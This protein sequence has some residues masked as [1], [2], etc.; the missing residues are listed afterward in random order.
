MAA[1]THRLAGGAL[2]ALAGCGGGREAPPPSAPVVAASL[3]EDPAGRTVVAEVDGRP[4]YADCVARQA[5]ARGI[6]LRAAVDECIGFELLAREAER[7]GYAAHPEVLEARETEVVRAFIDREFAAGF[8]GPEDVP[9]AEVE[10]FYRQY[11]DQLYVHPEW[12]TSRHVLARL[13]FK[14][15]DG[16]VE[17][18][19]ARAFVDALR[20]GLAGRRPDAAELERVAREL[21]AHH[22]GVKLQI[23]E[24]PGSLHDQ[25]DPAYRDA[26]MALP[27]AGALSGPVRSAFGWH[28]ILVTEVH[29]AVNQ[30]VDEAAADIRGKIFE[31]VRRRAF[32]RWASSLLP[33]KPDIDEQWLARLAAT[34]TARAQPPTGTA[35]P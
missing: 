5:A 11:K 24:V 20:R 21:A 3:A 4:I 6:D 15:P 17:E 30:S 13:P 35:T 8:D 31:A 29:P 9:R 14:A 27:G 23:E 34:D 33:G 2:L 16:T 12:R 1:R 22:P 19:A 7:R 32:L 25:L 10:A 26:L 18:R 28:L